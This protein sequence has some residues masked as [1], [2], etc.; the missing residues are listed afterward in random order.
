MNIETNFKKSSDFYDNNVRFEAIYHLGTMFFDEFRNK[1]AF[2]NDIEQIAFA[3]GIEQSKLQNAVDAD[4][5]SE[6]ISYI[7]YHYKKMG[8]LCKV[9]TPKKTELEDGSFI[10]HWGYSRTVYIYSESFDEVVKTAVEWANSF[11][12]KS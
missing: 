12:N 4:C 10:Y 5:F 6:K 11:I 1:D 2:D 3:L 8:F 9:V 7:L